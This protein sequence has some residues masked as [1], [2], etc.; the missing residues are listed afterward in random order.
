MH[1][2]PFKTETTV[3][4][5]TDLVG[6]NSSSMQ[7]SERLLVHDGKITYSI[8]KKSRVRGYRSKQK[9]YIRKAGVSHA[10]DSEN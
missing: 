4:H 7:F 10:A 6:V 8:N 1:F 5:S 9:A 3:S 2:C